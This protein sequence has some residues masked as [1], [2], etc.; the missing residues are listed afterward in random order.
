MFKNVLIATDGSELA[1][2]AVEQGLSLAKAL[3]ARATAVTVTESWDA[4]SRAALAQ[5][6]V[7]NPVADY[8]QRM[9]AAA[10]RILWSVGERAKKLDAPCGTIHVK[11]RHPA[12]GII[13][14][15]QAQACD[16]IVIASHGHRGPATPLIGSQA[17]RVV[18]LS[19]VPVLV[20]R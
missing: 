7:C 4:L 18:T 15:A 8:E 17:N 19:P 1:D 6:Q 20:C 13:E 12:E 16:L 11:G 2:R 9:A 3:G 10:N 14:T 5:A